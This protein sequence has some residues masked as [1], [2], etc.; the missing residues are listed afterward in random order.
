LRPAQ[1]MDSSLRKGCDTST[2]SL[3]HVGATRE[4]RRHLPPLELQGGRSKVAATEAGRRTVPTRPA[5][6]GRRP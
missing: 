3:M 2:S 4:P 6:R 5:R 1:V